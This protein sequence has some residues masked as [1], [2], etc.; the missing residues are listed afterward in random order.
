MRIARVMSL[1]LVGALLVGCGK[2]PK[3]FGGRDSKPPP[4]AELAVPTPD[5]VYSFC[6]T[7]LLDANG[8]QVPVSTGLR[9]LLESAVREGDKLVLSG[10][11]ADTE[12]KAPAVEVLFVARGQIIT[13]TRLTQARPD[14]VQALQLGATTNFYGFRFSVDVAQLGEPMV[15]FAVDRS[16]K[17]LALGTAR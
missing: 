8:R 15:T 7:C 1:L 14:V 17:V 12:A 2:G 11:A 3:L 4:L 6:A 5:T 16:G 13:R 9:G 10:W